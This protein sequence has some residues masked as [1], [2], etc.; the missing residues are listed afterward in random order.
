MDAL[1]AIMVV[2]LPNRP[3]GTVNLILYTIFVT[4]VFALTKD[5]LVACLTGDFSRQPYYARQKG[6][7]RGNS[8]GKGNKPV[9]SEMPSASASE[10]HE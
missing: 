7:G 2:V 8:G 9:P 3:E 10:F 5:L 6:P 1:M 4:M